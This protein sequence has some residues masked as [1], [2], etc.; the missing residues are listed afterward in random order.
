[1]S[2]LRSA[3]VFLRFQQVST[4]GGCTTYLR[5]FGDEEI[6]I[7]EEGG[8]QAPEDLLDR[9]WLTRTKMGEILYERRHDSVLDSIL[10]IG[11][12][13]GKGEISEKQ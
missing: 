7:T 5:K 10:Q 12:W 6:C 2:S 9:V 3:L 1:M 11:I 4:G 13:I 8:H